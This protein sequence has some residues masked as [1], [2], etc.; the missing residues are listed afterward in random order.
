MLLEKKVNSDARYNDVILRPS[1]QNIA[2]FGL[3]LP[4]SHSSITVGVDEWQSLVE[5]FPIVVGFF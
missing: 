5:A 2:W 4:L 3:S 1:D